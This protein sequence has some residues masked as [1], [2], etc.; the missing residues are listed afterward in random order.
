M[1]RV[2]KP[3]V[4]RW[5]SFAQSQQQ[6]RLN[7]NQS[8][9]SIQTLPNSDI[10]DLHEDDKEGSQGYGSKNWIMR[11]QKAAACLRGLQ[12]GAVPEDRLDE[13]SMRDILV[14]IEPQ[15]V[16]SSDTKMNQQNQNKTEVSNQND[17]ENEYL[18][19]SE[20]D[21]AK[22][23]GGFNSLNKHSYGDPK[24]EILPSTHGINSVK[25]TSG[26]TE[27]HI[28]CS[29]GAIS[30]VLAL[31][32][33]GEIH[34]NS[35]NALGETPL[36][37]AAR[38][39]PL[40]FLPV[41]VHLLQ[42]GA[43]TTIEDYEGNTPLDVA[44]ND[45]ISL[46]MMLHRQRIENFEFTSH[47]RCWYRS[48]CIQN[49]NHVNH[50][51]L[52]REIV[53]LTLTQH[54]ERRAAALEKTLREENGG[55]NSVRASSS[56][57]GSR[58]SRS[59]S[60]SG[61]ISASRMERIRRMQ[62]GHREK[63]IMMTSS[64]DGDGSMDPN[65]GS[66]DADRS[67]ESLAP[68]KVDQRS[69]WQS[70][71]RSRP[72]NS[73]TSRYH[74]ALSFLRVRGARD[75]KGFAN[76]IDQQENK[77]ARRV[78]RM[79]R[80]S[81][82]DGLL[83]SNAF[84]RESV[85]QYEKQTAIR[86]AIEATQAKIRSFGTN[87]GTD[88]EEDTKSHSDDS[89][90]DED[91]EEDENDSDSEKDY[92]KHE[93]EEH[94][95]KDD[96]GLNCRE[97]SENDD[98]DL[99]PGTADGML[100]TIT[101]QK[102]A[103]AADAA[104]LMG[105]ASLGMALQTANSVVGDPFRYD[106][107]EDSGREE[108]NDQD[109]SQESKR[110]NGS[111]IARPANSDTA[112]LMSGWGFADEMMNKEENNA[113]S[114]DLD[115]FYTTG[116]INMDALSIP[117]IP[118]APAARRNVSNMSLRNAN[119]GLSSK[120]V[121]YMK[122]ND[123]NNLRFSL[124]RV[125]TNIGKMAPAVTMGVMPVPSH[126]LVRSRISKSNDASYKQKRRGGTNSREIPPI[127]PP[128]N[129]GKDGGSVQVSFSGSVTGGIIE[130]DDV[131]F[132]LDD[133]SSQD[134]GSEDLRLNLG[135]KDS[136]YID[137]TEIRIAHS[138]ALS[139][140]EKERNHL[141][142]MWEAAEAEVN[143]FEDNQHKLIEIE[144]TLVEEQES[145]TEVL[146]TIM[147][148]FRGEMKKVKT[149]I[150]KCQEDVQ[151]YVDRSKR[152]REKLDEE[153]SI[154]ADRKKDVAEAKR[155]R[156]KRLKSLTAAAKRQESSVAELREHLSKVDAVIR[157][158]NRDEDK[159]KAK[160][161]T[162]QAANGEQTKDTLER[163]GNVERELLR[164]RKEK[165][166]DVMRKE[167][168]VQ[169]LQS[170]EMQIREVI[171]EQRRRNRLYLDAEAQ[172]N[173]IG[174][175][176]PGS[177]G[178]RGMRGLQR[179]MTP[180]TPPLSRGSIT[181]LT[182]IQEGDD[183]ENDE[184][185]EY[186]KNIGADLNSHST[187]GIRP[188][189]G[190][191]LASGGIRK[192]DMHDLQNMQRTHSAPSGLT[193]NM[194]AWNDNNLKS[195]E[196]DE[197][198][199][200]D[201][202]MPESDGPF[203]LAPPK[204]RRPP[205]NV[206]EWHKQNKKRLRD[207]NFNPGVEYVPTK[208]D[209][210]ELA[211]EEKLK[212]Q[213]KKLALRQA[214]PFLSLAPTT[215]VKEVE[216]RYEDS[217]KQVFKQERDRM[218]IAKK[219][220][221]EQDHRER[222]IRE[223]HAEKA[224]REREEM[225]RNETPEER[226]KRLIRETAIE[227]ENEERAARIKEEIAEE[228]K[229]AAE[230]HDDTLDG[231]GHKN[232]D[233]YDFMAAE[234][235]KR[236]KRARKAAAAD[237]R[238]AAREK[239]GGLP[240]REDILAEENEKKKKYDKN[241]NTESDSS[242]SDLEWR[243]GW[244]EHIPEE[245][246]VSQEMYERK[247]SK[248][249]GED[250]ASEDTL[251]PS[252][253]KDIEFESSLGQDSVVVNTPNTAK[254]F[255]N[256][257]VKLVPKG[258]AAQTK[259]QK[260]SNAARRRREIAAAKRKQEFARRR[261]EEDGDEDGVKAAIMAIASIDDKI[262]EEEILKK[263]AIAERRRGAQPRVVGEVDWHR[264]SPPREISK[265]AA[266]T[267]NA[268][269]TVDN[270]KWL[271]GNSLSL[272]E[273]Q[274]QGIDPLLNV[275]KH[276]GNFAGIALSA[277]AREK[278]F[279]EVLEKAANGGNLDHPEELME[280]GATASYRRSTPIQ[281]DAP[282]KGKLQV[283]ANS[284]K[285]ESINDTSE[286]SHLEPAA[287]EKDHSSDNI[288]EAS[289]S[290]SQLKPVSG[291]AVGSYVKPD[292][293]S[294]QPPKTAPS[295]SGQTYQNRFA[296]KISSANPLPPLSQP[297]RSAPDLLANTKI[298][299][300]SEKENQES[301]KIIDQFPPKPSESNG[302]TDLALD[303]GS[304]VLSAGSDEL[305]AWD[306]VAD[307]MSL[308]SLKRSRLSSKSLVN[309]LN[310]G[311]NSNIGDASTISNL[312]TLS[313]I[314]NSA[315]KNPGAVSG[316]TGNISKKSTYRPKL[317]IQVYDRLR[318]ESIKRKQNFQERVKAQK[319]AAV[320]A[321]MPSELERQE[322]ESGLWAKKPINERPELPCATIESY[323]EE[324]ILKGQLN[325]TN[326]I[327][328][329]HYPI[330]IRTG[331]EAGIS[332]I[333]Q[334]HIEK[335]FKLDANAISDG[336]SQYLEPPISKS[337][338]V[339][340]LTRPMTAENFSQHVN[341]DP[342]YYQ[343]KHL[344]DPPVR[345][346][347]SP[348]L[349][350][351]AHLNRKEKNHVAPNTK[352]VTGFHR[353]QKGNEDGNRRAG[354]SSAGSVNASE[355]SDIAG[356][357]FHEMNRSC[358]DITN[359]EYDATADEEREAWDAFFDAAFKESNKTEKAQSDVHS[360]SNDPRAA[361]SVKGHM[362]KTPTNSRGGNGGHLNP[363]GGSETLSRPNSMSNTSDKSGD[364]SSIKILPQSNT[365]S[366]QRASSAP[367]SSPQR[368][369]RKI[370]SKKVQ[371][372]TML[373]HDAAAHAQGAVGG[374]NFDRGNVIESLLTS[375]E[376]GHRNDDIESERYLRAVK[377]SYGVRS[378]SARRLIRASNGLASASSVLLEAPEPLAEENADYNADG[379][380]NSILLFSKESQKA[381]RKNKHSVQGRRNKLRNEAI[382]PGSRA[383]LEPLLQ[384]HTPGTPSRP[385]S[386]PQKSASLLK[387]SFSSSLVLA[388]ELSG[389]DLDTNIS[390]SKVDSEEEEN[391]LVVDDRVRV[392]Q[393]ITD[394]ARRSTK[395]ASKSC[396]PK[397]ILPPR[398]STSISNTYKANRNTLMK[399]EFSD[400]GSDSVSSSSVRPSTSPT[401][402]RSS[403]LM[404]SQK[405]DIKLEDGLVGTHLSLSLTEN[406]AHIEEMRQ[407][408]E[409]IQMKRA[410]ARREIW[411]GYKNNV[412]LS[413]PMQA[414][415]AELY[416]ELYPSHVATEELS[417]LLH[418]RS[419]K[420]NSTVI[421][422]PS[423]SGKGEAAARQL[424]Q[425]ER[426]EGGI[427][428]Q[429][430]EIVVGEGNS[431]SKDDNPSTLDADHSEFEILEDMKER[432]KTLADRLTNIREQQVELQEDLHRD[433]LNLRQSIQ[434]ACD[435]DVNAAIISSR[436]Q[437]LVPLD[438][439]SWSEYT[440]PAGATP[441][442]IAAA[443]I[444]G[445]V[446]RI[447]EKWND[448]LE[449]RIEER[450]SMDKKQLRKLDQREQQV[451]SM[452][453]QNVYESTNYEDLISRNSV[454]SQEEH[455]HKHNNTEDVSSSANIEESFSNSANLIRDSEFEQS[456]SIA[457]EKSSGEMAGSIN[458]LTKSSSVKVPKNMVQLTNNND[459]I[460]THDDRDTANNNTMA[461]PLSYPVKPALNSLKSSPKV[462]DNMKVNQNSTSFARLKINR[463]KDLD[464]RR[465]S[466]RREEAKMRKNNIAIIRKNLP[467]DLDLRR[468]SKRRG[469][470]ETR[471]KKIASI[472][473]SLSKGL[474]LRRPSKRRAQTVTRES[475]IAS[476]KKS[477]PVGLDLRRPSKQR[478]ETAARQENIARVIMNLPKGLD[479]RRPSKRREETA[480]R[481]KIVSSIKMSLPKDLD[482]RRPSKRR[483]EAV[484]TEKNNELNRISQRQG[485][486]VD[487]PST[488][489][490]NK[491]ERC[492]EP[493]DADEKEN[494]LGRKNSDHQ[495]ETATDTSKYQDRK[496]YVPA[497]DRDQVSRN[498]SR[499]NS[500]TA[501]RRLLE[502]SPHPLQHQ[503]MAKQKEK[504]KVRQ[505]SKAVTIVKK[506]EAT[507][508]IAQSEKRK[509]AKA[510]GVGLNKEKDQLDGAALPAEANPKEA[511]PKKVSQKNL[512]LANSNSLD[513]NLGYSSTDIATSVR[514]ETNITHSKQKK[515]DEG[516]TSN[517][518]KAQSSA[519]ENRKSVYPTI[520]HE[521]L[522]NLK[523]SKV[524]SKKGEANSSA[525]LPS[526]SGIA[527]ARAVI[528][529]ANPN[530]A[531][532][533]TPA[534]RYDAPA[535]EY[536]ANEAKRI[537]KL[538]AELE[539]S[540]YIDSHE[541][542]EDLEFNSSEDESGASDIEEI[543][544]DAE[545]E[546]G[547]KEW[548]SR[549]Q[550]RRRRSL[551]KK[552]R[553]LNITSNAHREKINQAFEAKRRTQLMQDIE[554]G[555][556][557]QELLQAKED[558]EETAKARL[559]SK[560][561]MNLVAL[562]KQRK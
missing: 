8:N 41:V 201:A 550:A 120:K 15:A 545:F 327:A 410:V 296:Q 509:D 291:G 33:E 494:D 289:E 124:E 385:A 400:S 312:T 480:M 332:E 535:S 479:L 533:N 411:E 205:S 156:S 469:E 505:K 233:N 543:D 232:D 349:G 417:D 56:R 486:D 370:K 397:S 187:S 401:R 157:G 357:R 140:L 115:D 493:S 217:N 282:D 445:T 248:I 529:N 26:N 93:D 40:M 516:W 218:E 433:I 243:H 472:K 339:K 247:L 307:D 330:I 267:I 524:I 360:D 30:K 111:N 340:S 297:P 492:S 313:E 75:A 466:K 68:R 435:E 470:R 491:M 65:A 285:N 165:Q 310:S 458:K 373:T 408:Q 178:V 286:E 447:R 292:T 546:E 246:A 476:I 166:D 85:A 64:I 485:L 77:M 127:P 7:P 89:A 149:K 342:G 519:G 528:H 191:G 13:C 527:A 350:W 548:I 177:G 261:A 293:V 6:R 283:K 174:M 311:S 154:L 503:E 215:R 381:I 424:L 23:S 1:R 490:V 380:E 10:D 244:D 374:S 517:D 117:L 39:L 197:K 432:E 451:L 276:V 221:E 90:D 363:W 501:T 318:Y 414:A 50:T 82:R 227:K 478:A 12:E 25:D 337:F 86:E 92:D 460:S 274:M 403:S 264:S 265:Q 153:W 219:K 146:S 91:I 109:D 421:V 194:D 236:A 112:G 235:R 306:E 213:R 498:Q 211:A 31:L 190:S 78:R 338:V 189:T 155:T 316:M 132:P 514:N 253:N 255:G 202:D 196:G 147:G 474:D 29:K 526:G 462:V 336:E 80:R 561:E 488:L 234:K 525:T 455:I 104:T 419:R 245:V 152:I 268:K 511:S 168:A 67:I 299:D 518:P 347:S 38:H 108:N 266:N 94:E 240:S 171:D 262:E 74:R 452:L 532:W 172:E 444:G 43:S 386:S 284:I 116:K 144:K 328:S 302:H 223:Q 61:A 17:R 134:P 239:R 162:M 324:G 379:I 430:E 100:M 16:S 241:G 356:K 540:T 484:T 277:D 141:E 238:R 87:D 206:K 113:G 49:W 34:I 186:G 437:H 225:L 305:A 22:T 315:N 208:E 383:G 369:E 429:K 51:S 471:E 230:V 125:L 45:V 308:L 81:I 42:S 314:M 559:T 175:D 364:L 59:G 273:A 250:V 431:E 105:M 275:A 229:E 333:K 405:D 450:I 203:L 126:A 167:E 416:P 457:K 5:H 536:I 271:V 48:R 461:M 35:R 251:F 58:R 334:R 288:E 362:M 69:G 348:M 335:S 28:A 163:V 170:L 216:I 249:Q 214:H 489:E 434:E 522:T 281:Q 158:I 84:L 309:G 164:V 102:K 9:N 406:Q 129:L 98:E 176:R 145:A 252:S 180:D 465:P 259:A 150:R 449:Q 560:A 72:K 552:R 423:N 107:D 294:Y 88:D 210:D 184:G 496:E 193:G 541:D 3:I 366:F 135:A 558:A 547:S 222:I 353:A 382:R 497:G 151:G 341:A 481:A 317:G 534:F 343:A 118:D 477:L 79:N 426:N 355:N 325:L 398:P 303:G 551:R 200:E 272:K 97:L 319:Q 161:A 36:H 133:T 415:Y 254:V 4:K 2:L 440:G 46:A 62:Q 188:V 371:E 198:E 130:D 269:S 143:G 512:K 367:A 391:G 388:P 390:L 394:L 404:L 507:K 539:E 18:A 502:H 352:F 270:A 428:E 142:E 55:A 515:K 475:A 53:H 454:V 483:K 278:R 44:T 456:L 301:G 378:K 57:P 418:S 554:L 192:S 173:G 257:E 14:Q 544:S 11:L 389:N 304:S 123:I 556:R 346:Q 24:S 204:R 212:L 442:E 331:S 131:G 70:A 256:F 181:A 263:E 508:A 510:R 376:Y 413:K 412:G 83:I 409:I 220:Q 207:P 136:D 530:H 300:N 139:R 453:E 110:I 402:L 553:L 295:D 73:W 368:G 520:S 387:S 71:T 148:R 439:N 280:W 448:I 361:L 538:E 427:L 298:I 199:E 549:E 354:I 128:D 242:D 407:M 504:T 159:L 420:S 119:S 499:P 329:K 96:G 446:R 63:N 463:P 422:V 436:E 562:L 185:E 345:P 231:D 459:K 114:D 76:L 195:N 467:K 396:P 521:K 182:S 542:E 290:L 358:E 523:N 37:C 106:S 122:E 320:A 473:K 487:M 393:S 287:C 60:R 351:H 344:E 321:M 137:W 260:K 482:L 375:D 27:L 500:R 372:S 359:V 464:L 425:T 95:T 438:S 237:A 531:P 384:R 399:N 52:W 209:E 99:R 557:I 323:A 101:T 279:K 513:S 103:S 555:R 537:A 183:E 138:I 377:A 54:R 20:S 169:D 21:E 226:E 224:R 19:E 160:I 66:I 258:F 322:V 179:G 443:R 468:P 392:E 228:H 326:S 506:H 47:E 441:E 395:S 32:K 365:V 495:F 121:K